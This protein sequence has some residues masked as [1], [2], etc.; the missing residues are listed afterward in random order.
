VDIIG[1]DKT[2]PPGYQISPHNLPHIPAI[3][4]YQRILTYMDFKYNIKLSPQ[5]IDN[6]TKAPTLQLQQ[7]AN[8]IIQQRADSK[9]HRFKN[10][11]T[12][13]LDDA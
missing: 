9:T 11:P 2:G 13:K 12:Q 7:R 4:T 5:H 1:T 10:S 3:L 6:H 8:S